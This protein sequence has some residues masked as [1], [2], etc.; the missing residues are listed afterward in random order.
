M[1]RHYRGLV[2]IPGFGF[3]T[4]ALSGSVNTKDL[5]IG[6]G[7]GLAGTLGV[8]W[9]VDR[10]VV[11]R[12]SDPRISMLVSRLM[13]LIGTAAT[14]A[15]LYYGQKKTAKAKAQLVGAVAAGAAVVTW[16]FLRDKFAS[17]TEL[18]NTQQK[19]ATAGLVS[20]PGLSAWNGIIVDNPRRNYGGII[21]DN[22]DRARLE[23]LTAYSQAMDSG[24]EELEAV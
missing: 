16:D 11:P 14:G 9:A 21:V 19:A 5:F 1:R 8:R 17:I 2:S 6:G 24:L 20:I 3:V 13:P 7:L 10:F 22:P 12:I 23:A 18:L 4:K 15:A